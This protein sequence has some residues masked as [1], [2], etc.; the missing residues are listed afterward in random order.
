MSR[1]ILCA[2]VLMLSGCGAYTTISNVWV[3]PDIQQRNLQGTLV[4]A[5]THQESVR[6]DFEDAYTKVLRRNGVKAIASHTLIGGTLDQSDKQDIIA[7]ARQAGLDTLLVSHY[8]GTEEEPVFHPG[9][10]YYTVVPEYGP[11]YHDRGFDGHYGRLIELGST[12]DVWTTNRYVFIVSD[13]YQTDNGDHLWQATSE[14]ISP[15][16]KKALR[17]ASIKAFIKQMK[18]QGL[19]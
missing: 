7:A 12:P 5:V 9:Q 15:R 18:S 16:N 8:A 11:Y 6:I 2:L 10:R 4:I 13:L 19:L 17:N 14:T 1:V 3:A